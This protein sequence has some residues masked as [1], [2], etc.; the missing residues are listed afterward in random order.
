MQEIIKMLRPKHW[1]KNLLVFIIPLLSNSLEIKELGLYMCYFMI[2]SLFIS[3]TYI[4]NDLIDIESDKNHPVKKFRPIASGAISQSSALIISIFLLI[5]TLVIAFLLST[6]LLNFLMLYLL[7]TVLYSYIFKYIKYFDIFYLTVFFIL[8]I[9]LGAFLFNNEVTL[10]FILFTFFSTG[11]ISIAKKY[12]I[13]NSASDISS[14]IKNTL[15]KNYKKQSLF[16]LFRTFAIISEV[17]FTIWI[18]DSSSIYNSSLFIKILSVALFTIFL[19][20]LIKYTKR[21]EAEDIIELVL[22]K[23]DLLFPFTIFILLLI[24]GLSKS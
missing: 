11:A 2:I 12:S 24:Y 19:F 21:F 17:I 5:T 1:S 8:R 13:M 7:L 9:T 23:N 16:N 3:G 10:I 6:T 22:K 18:F 14:K 15:N 4:I 20:N